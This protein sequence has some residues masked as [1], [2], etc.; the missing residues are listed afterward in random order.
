MNEFNVVI[1]RSDWQPRDIEII[2]EEESVVFS[3]HMTLDQLLK[4][5]GVY[6]STSD[7]RRAGR[8]GP[9]PFGY[10]EI[11]ASKLV[12]LFVWNPQEN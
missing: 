8:H 12:K 7:A 9:I 10:S 2:F 1:S 4:E 5:L 3:D 11:K 6:K